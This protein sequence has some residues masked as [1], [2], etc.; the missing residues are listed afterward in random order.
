MSKQWVSVKLTIKH[1][2]T[3]PHSTGIVGL[4]GMTVDFGKE[5]YVPLRI[6]LGGIVR[7][8]IDFWIQTMR[9]D[10]DTLNAELQMLWLTL[11][12]ANVQEQQEASPFEDEP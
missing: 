7:R 2:N 1:R 4:T 3:G 8:I 6:L 9:Y 11:S 10:K 5:E 12:A